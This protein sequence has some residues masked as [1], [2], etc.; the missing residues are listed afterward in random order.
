PIDDLHL[1]SGADAELCLSATGC[2]SSVLCRTRLQR[3]DHAG[4]HGY[5]LSTGALR[6]RDGLDGVAGDLVR[7]VEGER[8]VEFFIAGGG[9]PRR[10]RQWGEAPTPTPQREQHAPG[11]RVRGGR[12]LD[13]PRPRGPTVLHMPKRERPADVGVLHRTP[14]FIQSLPQVG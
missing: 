10:V 8:S 7:L 9:Q 11:E 5:S 6:L 4:P 12:E 1:V 3:A 2:N 14:G 13:R